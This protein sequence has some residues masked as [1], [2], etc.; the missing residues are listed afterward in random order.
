[1]PAPAPA[2]CCARSS[3]CP[4]SS[5][6]GARAQASR[7][8]GSRARSRTVGRGAADRSA[9][10]RHRPVS[11]RTPCGSAATAPRSS[12]SDESVRIGLTKGADARLRYF[13]AGSGYLS[14]A[15]RLNV[16]A[17]SATF[18]AQ[19]PVFVLDGALA[20]EL[21]RR[22]ADLADPLWSAKCLLEQPELIRAGASRLFQGRRRCRDHR[23]LSGDASRALRRRGIER[24]AAARLMR[25]A[26]ALAAAA[27]DEFWSEPPNRARRLRPLI[28]ASVGPYGAMLADGSEYRGHYARERSRSSRPFTG[29]GSKCWPT[30]A[31]ICSPAKPCR[32]CARRWSLAQPAAGVSGDHRLDQLLLPRRRAQLRG[33][34]DRRA[35][36][37][38]CAA[39]PRSPPSA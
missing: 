31:P 39:M 28:A 27:R 23:D 30:R 37:P 8:A 26:V 4:G 33:R 11:P 10:R 25:D 15:R 13:V 9:A 22:G 34:G 36:P 32:A 3:R 12:R 1:M 24:D 18:L 5:T 21:E 6:C 17:R 35:A 16:I 38:R 20:T 14:G 2:C 7:V 19:R 29:R